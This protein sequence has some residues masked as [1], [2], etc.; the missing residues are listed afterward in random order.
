MNNITDE[1]KAYL[2]GLTVLY[3]EDDEEIVQLT[4]RFLS[5]YTGEVLSA[6]NASAGLAVYRQ[7]KP[8]IIVTDVRMP[9][10]DGLTMA[11][12]IRSQDASIPIIVLT[13][14]DQPNYL[15]RSIN[16]GV[17]G[18]VCKPAEGIRLLSVLYK[19][20]RQI[21][22][23]KA[24][25]QAVQDL[26]KRELDLIEKNEELELV[27]KGASLGTWN[28]DIP[29]GDIVFNERYF[30][31]LGYQP[32]ELP[33]N[34]STWE[35]LLH[36]EDAPWV[37]QNLKEHLSG[38]APSYCTEHRLLHKT[39]HWV[40]IYDVGKVL[41]RNSDG[42]PRR[43]F[44]IHLD[45]TEKKEA[46]DR[47][48]AAKE[49]SNAIVHNFLETL[50]VVN[51]ELTITRVNQT[52][53]ELLGYEMEELIQQRVTQFFLDDAA[54]VQ[55]VFTFYT[56]ENRNLFGIL[57]IMRNVELSCRKKNRDFLPMSFNISPFHD[58]KGTIIGVV[59]GGKDI[60]SLH[61]T[62]N[63]IDRQ[64]KFIESLLNIIPVGIAT[65]ASPTKIL[66]T[67]NSFEQIIK[68]CSNLLHKSKR[69]C[70]KQLIKTVISEIESNNEFPIQLYH[71]HKSIHL[72]CHVDSTES[73]N[74]GINIISMIDMTEMVNMQRQMATT[75]K[76]EAI[77]QLATGISH[78]IN[79]PI[80][81]ILYNIGFID[82]FFAKTYNLLI[83]ISKTDYSTLPIELAKVAQNINFEP[84]L[85]EVPDCLAETY[86][87]IKRVAK[88][89]A[90]LREFSHPGLGEKV[91]TDINHALDSTLIVC[92]SEW[93]YL[94]ELTTEFDQ[95]L[96]L[97]PCFP[98]QMN[99]VFLNLIINAS[100]AIETQKALDP[101]A[102][103][104]LTV[105]TRRNGDFAEIMVMDTGCGIAQEIRP[106]IFE[107]FFTTKEVGKGTG[108][109]L[110]FAYDI[111]VRKHL[112][113][114]ECLSE[115]GQGAAFILRL[116]LATDEPGLDC[117][118]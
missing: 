70:S 33:P 56:E 16:M 41:Q 10:V 76:L 62:I 24:L 12:E 2:K 104:R 110:A 91:P 11:E 40:W 85:K 22:V 25:K 63:E 75:Q 6:S 82:N 66:M 100:H 3:V 87:G 34:Y 69:E 61:K 116:P 103:H 53:C 27:L 18:Y 23:E 89:I 42:T 117:P 64:K 36:P 94:A 26:R 86:E 80:Q 59:A 39:G 30:S 28:W 96:P 97:V 37:L 99:Q 20:A 17:D 93:K 105:T 35:S 48:E 55:A 77:G 4:I 112:G 29:T 72:K 58:D 21:R 84:L 106:R 15:M 32:D 47:L 67:N 57:P 83:E 38:T 74:P 95:D 78:E 73:I 8:D 14:F 111:V 43:A 52:T 114:I 45:I 79:S 98:D 51:T 71:D 60:S 13:A 46:A 49:E 113:R 31:M 9:G 65:F 108:Q 50:F 81:Y 102:Q 19:C 92:H 44:G 90:A 115:P 88:I 5:R 1:D 68:D 101:E 107:P 118:R 7:S 54:Y 109:G